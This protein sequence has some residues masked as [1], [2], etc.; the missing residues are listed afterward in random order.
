[1]GRVLVVEDERQLRRCLAG[2]LGRRGWQ[3]TEA[4]SLAEARAEL[5]DG[6]FD[7]AVLDVG[8]P[9]GDGLDLLTRTGPRRSLI[10]SARPDA[11]HYERR[12]VLHHL[13]KPL[14][15]VTVAERVSSLCTSPL[16]TERSENAGEMQ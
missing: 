1:M 5:R 3:V 16:R 8:L 13:P 12:G 15:L 2:Y 4:G 11:Q 7:A 9:D 10:V 6:V 14:D